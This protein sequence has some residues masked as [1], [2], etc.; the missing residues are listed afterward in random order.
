MKRLY[1]FLPIVIL[2]AVLI[3][4]ANSTG[5]PGGKTG[6]PGDSNETCTECHT[7]TASS[8]SGWITSNIPANGY[9]PGETYLITATGTHNGV[10]KFGFELTAETSGG[11]K[12]GTLAITEATRTKLTNQNKAVTHKAAG[13]VPNGNTNTWTVNWTAPASDVGS[14]HFYAAFNAA[15]GNGNNSGDVI[16][17]SNLFVNAAQPGTLVSVTP[18]HA[19]QNQT[20]VVTVTGQNTNWTNPAPVVKFRNHNNTSEQF[21]ATQVQVISQTVLHATFTVPIGATMGMYD[22]LADELILPSCFM[23][24]IVNSIE[25]ETAALPTVYP[26]PASDIVWINTPT[27]TEFSIYDI[28]GKLIIQQVVEQGKTSFDLSGF[29]AGIYLVVTEN[30]IGNEEVNKLI[31]R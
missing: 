2:P 19:D 25:D 1:K 20:V 13:N 18:D 31:I 17:K 8:A 24:T 7:G 21:S 29:K 11:T 3:L 28:T 22:L 27:T 26:N 15:N 30:N 9:T 6:S 10:V 12:I 23:V 14:I 5:S 4:Y 16:Y